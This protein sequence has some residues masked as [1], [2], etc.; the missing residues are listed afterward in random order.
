MNAVATLPEQSTALHCTPDTSPQA[1]SST[2]TTTLFDLIAAMQD[3][4]QPGDEALIV[5]A[6][7]QWIRSGRITFQRDIRPLLHDS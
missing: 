3:S 5:P 6:V 2:T 4:A 1:L 7:A